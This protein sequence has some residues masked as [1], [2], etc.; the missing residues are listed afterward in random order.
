MSLADAATALGIAPNS[1]RSRFKAGKI[2]GERDNLGKLWVWLDHAVE[3]SNTA[4][5]NAL[6]AHLRTLT[7][8]LNLAQAEVSALRIR[9]SVADHLEGQIVG[10]ETLRDEVRA[11][12]DHWREIAERALA[13]LH[14]EPKVR[15]SL[16]ARL[17]GR[18]D[19]QG[20]L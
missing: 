9:A 3:G 2:R 18:S 19:R 20:M 11:D 13:D 17:F 5:V 4:Q 6:E 8:Q 16:W 15:R 14:V 10:L 7:D 1:V 12:R